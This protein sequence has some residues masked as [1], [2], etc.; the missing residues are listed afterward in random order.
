MPDPT[1]GRPLVMGILNVTP[2]SFSDGGKWFGHERAIVRAHEMIGEG[3]DVIDVGGEST[4]PG[5][6][7]VSAEEELRRVI[8]VIEALAGQVRVSVD[9]TK[10]VVA[11]AAVGAGA[12][13]INDVS[14]SLWPVAARHGVGWVAMHRKGTPA[15]MQRD[16]HYEDVVGEVAGLLIDR[17]ARANEAGVAEV[18]I[19]PG[20]GFGKTVDHNLALLGSLGDLVA[21]G[22]PVMVGTSRKSFLSTLVSSGGGSSVP[23][24]E[25]LPGSLSTATWAMVRGARMVRVHDVAATVQAALLVGRVGFEPMAEADGPGALGASHRIGTEYPE[26]GT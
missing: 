11:D 13:L 23:V 7:P 18:W 21:T 4:R 2:D 16:P 20:I 26:V 5:A 9:T 19:D 17:A 22:Y 1:P 12:S 3:A 14:A 24:D 15:T 8:P 10:D 25:R 6:E